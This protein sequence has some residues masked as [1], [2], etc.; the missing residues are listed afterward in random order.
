MPG[1]TA[2]GINH[3]LARRLLKKLP[4][5][6]KQRNSVLR[7]SVRRLAGRERKLGPPLRV[8][9]GFLLFHLLFLE[10]RA[11]FF[12]FCA[13][14]MRLGFSH[15]RVRLHSVILRT[16]GRLKLALFKIRKLWACYSHRCHSSCSG[17]RNL[18]NARNSAQVIRDLHSGRSRVQRRM[19]FQL[20]NSSCTA[21]ESR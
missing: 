18:R 6:A 4:V 7:V 8:P 13:K 10:L 5:W 3:S 1:R 11:S 2:V 20:Y 9:P 17:G 21:N 19:Q 12:A 15:W 14:P 16:L